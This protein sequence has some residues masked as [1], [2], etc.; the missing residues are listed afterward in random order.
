MMTPD[1]PEAIG[2]YQ[3][4][5][6]LGH[7]GMGE[8]FLG[9]HAGTRVAVKRIHPGLAADP[10]FRKR[11]A[12]EVDLCRRV[13]SKTCASY[14]DCELEIPRP[15]LATEYIAGPDL[16]EAITA[17]GALARDQAEAV[18]LGLAEALR[19]IHSAGIIHRDLKPSNVILGIDGPCVIDFG[20][21]RA[22]DQ[23]AFTRTG[24]AIGSPGWMAPEQLRSGQL[25]EASDVF[26]W[27]ALVA[28]ASSGSPPFGESLPETLMYRVLNESPDLSG[29]P[30]SLRSLCE[31]ALSK[32][33]ADRPTPEQLVTEL[34]G[35]DSVNELDAFVTQRI[36]RTWLFV[37]ASVA[38]QRLP[39]AQPSNPPT[40]MAAVGGVGTADPKKNVVQR[41]K[42][43]FGIAAGAA[44]LVIVL[45]GGYVVTGSGKGK[46]STGVNATAASPSTSSS[47]ES[48]STAAQLDA[49]RAT[50]ATYAETLPKG[51]ATPIISNDG[52]PT[53]TYFSSGN[54]PN[55][56]IGTLSIYEY[57]D[58][59]VR[60][61]IQGLPVSMNGTE[62]TNPQIVC[63]RADGDL[64]VPG[65]LSNSRYPSMYIDLTGDG[66]FEMITQT[67]GTTG[68]PQLA[69]VLTSSTQGIWE[70]VAFGPGPEP[71]V[72]RESL[73]VDVPSRPQSKTGYCDAPI[74]QCPM[75]T[76]NWTYNSAERRF[77][78]E[79]ST[80]ATSRLVPTELT[81]PF[82][83]EPQKCG[84]DASPKPFPHSASRTYE[85]TATTG[86]WSAPSTASSLLRTIE[87]A[88]LGPGGIGCP[89]GKGPVVAVECQVMNG[90]LVNGPFGNDPKWLRTTYDGVV[91]YL[92]DQWVDTEWD[93]GTVQTSGTIPV[94]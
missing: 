31:R 53:L 54:L 43:A 26:A 47:K 69:V 37:P 83:Y 10:E 16:Q 64:N 58:G 72:V 73:N 40:T 19:Q 44:A 55:P 52:V 33:P 87:V 35:T 27:G 46:P 8:V 21:A 6:R 65:F 86:V 81:G 3:I 67:V 85:V 88:D 17:G 70:P 89:D 56:L 59:W 75:Q 7:G 24:G 57:R 4:L 39:D 45:I 34:L 22:A 49:A 14:V 32:D 23:T 20:I 18:A 28:Y 2:P 36:D 50:W 68:D 41:R 38:T 71:G 1:L 76:T 13:D 90:Q 12:R 74:Q 61:R 78:A 51:E 62:C 30:E 79:Q 15:W 48:P 42:L 94:C 25:S 66:R 84:I 92:T 91:G 80:V 63:V 29:V 93:A 77:V 9:D 5:A 11:F 82:S 60:G